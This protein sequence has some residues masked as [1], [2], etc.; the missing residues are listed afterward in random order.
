MTPSP[1]HLVV[2][3]SY[4]A[5]RLLIETVTHALAAWAP[6]WVVVDGSTDGSAAELDPLAE[7]KAGL[8]VITRARNG[9]KGAAVLDALVRA[10]QMGF[11]HV[12]V[13][14]SDG[15]HPPQCIAQLMALSA[16]HPDMAV[17]GQPIFGADAPRE[18]IYARRLSNLFVD[19]ETLWAGIGNSLFGFRVYP[20]RP[21]LRIMRST[22]WMRRFDFDAEAVVRLCWSGVRPMNV[23][24]PV[25][26]LSVLEGG[27]S[28]FRY[29]RDN[30]LLSW[31]HVRLL[32]GLLRRLPSVAG[33]RPIGAAGCSG[34]PSS[35]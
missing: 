4:N 27:V 28:H 5:G 9:G 20:V 2:I 11:T 15:Q 13:M 10:D 19:V 23:H 24:V 14:D 34:N 6:I 21:L 12:L 32:W 33:R 35:T 7:H 17:L 1:T 25:R 18:R 3:P 16:A 30:I 29:G 26:Y 8:T 31:M 22:R